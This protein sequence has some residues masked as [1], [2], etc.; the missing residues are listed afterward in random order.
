MGRNVDERRVCSLQRFLDAI[1]VVVDVFWCG[2]D[3]E[4]DGEGGEDDLERDVL[5]WEMARR[6]M[7]PE[8]GRNRLEEEGK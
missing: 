2:E 7:Q 5:I 3:G 4:D 8:K 1:C 6:G